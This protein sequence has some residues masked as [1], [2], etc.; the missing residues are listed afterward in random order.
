ML[1]IINYVNLNKY[2]RK[3]QRNASFLLK[4][5][6]TNT[7]NSSLNLLFSVDSGIWLLELSNGRNLAM[8]EFSKQQALNLL[9]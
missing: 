6:D 7:M 8:S 1:I 3:S 2:S 5:I 9:L 4:Q